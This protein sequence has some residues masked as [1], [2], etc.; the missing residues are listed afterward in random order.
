MSRFILI[1]VSDH[2]LKQHLWSH[3][4]KAHLW[5]VFLRI[6]T[7]LVVL[8]MGLDYW[9]FKSLISDNIPCIFLFG[10]LV[11]VI[12]ESGPHLVFVILS[13][14]GVIPFSVLFTSSFVRDGHGMLPL[15]SYTVKNSIL[16]KT[17]KLI[18]A[19]GMGMILYLAGW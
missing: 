17:L 1:A 6:F 10:A 12:P 4:I 19:L 15:L 7:A 5:R 16:V 9:N 13:A 18:F 11:V 8:H 14:E 3:I 2:H